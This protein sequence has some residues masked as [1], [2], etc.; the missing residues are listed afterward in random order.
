MV[1]WYNDQDIA[2]ADELVRIAG[3]TMELSKQYNAQ[4][5]KIQKK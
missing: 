4:L 5:R 3:E 2:T 1:T